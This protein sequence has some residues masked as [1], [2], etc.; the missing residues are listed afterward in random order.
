VMHVS[1]ATNEAEVTGM[2]QRAGVVDTISP[3]S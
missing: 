3:H 2:A 1:A